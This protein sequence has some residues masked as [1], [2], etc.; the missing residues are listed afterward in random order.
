ME[1]LEQQT[2]EKAGI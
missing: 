2:E 1:R